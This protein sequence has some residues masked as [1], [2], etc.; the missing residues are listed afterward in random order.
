MRVLLPFSAQQEEEREGRDREREREGKREGE[1]TGREISLRPMRA[2]DVIS[3]GQKYNVPLREALDGWPGVRCDVRPF[4]E[5]K[6]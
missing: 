6:G 4:R 5:R 1:R 3:H 2:E